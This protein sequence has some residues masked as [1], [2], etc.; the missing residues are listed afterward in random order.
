MSI[1]VL[2]KVKQLPPDKQKE[3]EDFIDYLLHKYVGDN[4]EEDI[5]E[6]R[7][8]NMGWA[9]GEIWMAEDF[10]DTPEDFKDYL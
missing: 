1:N 3:V 9:K 7:R 8:K 6:K 4:N 10:N 2:E 5:A